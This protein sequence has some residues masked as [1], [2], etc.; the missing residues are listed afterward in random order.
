MN[1]HPFPWL[2]PTVFYQFAKD[3][4]LDY[5]C[6]RCSKLPK[7]HFLDTGLE[8]GYIPRAS[9][10]ASTPEGLVN[11]GLSRHIPCVQTTC[12]HCGHIDLYS[13]Y[14]IHMWLISKQNENQN[15][16]GGLFGLGENNGV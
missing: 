4:G 2:T 14:Q 10:Y 7:L 6:N 3:V 16:P 8:E 12:V 1:N 15:P 9:S 5:H 13:M 11:M